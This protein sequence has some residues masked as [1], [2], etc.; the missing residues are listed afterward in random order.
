MKIVKHL[1]VRKEKDRKNKIEHEDTSARKTKI[2]RKTELDM[3]EKLNLTNY[4]NS[5]IQLLRDFREVATGNE[6]RY[7][8][9]SDMVELL[10]LDIILLTQLMH[11]QNI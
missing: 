10:D 3:I 11:Q 5:K 4:C 6:E 9:V 1:S 2:T 8:R 7:V